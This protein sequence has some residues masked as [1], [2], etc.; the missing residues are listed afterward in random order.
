MAK[1]N[2]NPI[3][4]M[5]DSTCSACHADMD[6]D[7]DIYCSACHGSASA[8]TSLLDAIG[9]TNAAEAMA[10]VAGFKQAASE[11]ATIREQVAKQAAAQAARDFDTEIASAKKSGLLASSD[12]HKRN[13]QALSYKGKP[14]ALVSL[15]G[16]IGA[17]DPLVPVAG[18]IVA[19]SEPPHSGV[20]GLVALTDEEKRLAHKMNVPLD[21]VMANKQRLL[22]RA[23]QA[24][25]TVVVDDEDDKDAA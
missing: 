16:F 9:A 19:P 21:K 4:G 12:E 5:A 10:M 23:A 15:R 1:N 3:A 13:K 11:V 17:L 8:M 6:D 20:G 14:D 2:K 18:K 7:D 24:P 25:S 22:L